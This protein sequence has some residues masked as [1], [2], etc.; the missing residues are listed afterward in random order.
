LCVGIV[1]PGATLR[2]VYEARFAAIEQ[3][4]RAMA[5][6]PPFVFSDTSDEDAQRYRAKS[7]TFTGYS[8][9]EGD[10]IE[11]ALG[12]RLPAALRQYLLTFGKASGDLFE[13]EDL[14]G[15]DE[16]LEFRMNAEELMRE[17]DPSL[18]LPDG[19]IVFLFHQG[20]VFQ[21]VR[22][23][24]GDDPKVWTY[25]EGETSFS[26]SEGTFLDMLDGEVDLLEKNW[27]GQHDLGGYYVTV[28][29]GGVTLT[30]PAAGERPLKSRKWWE[31]W[32]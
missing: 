16:W 30:Y 25:V 11:S 14:P 24:D 1:T 8:P 18:A 17:T 21:F 32:K 28:G 7:T 13:G 31:F 19:A 26:E 29:K 22:A 20:Y 5:A 15:I 9:E 6:D 4:L 10:R 12:L 3:R 2:V 27:D 23:G